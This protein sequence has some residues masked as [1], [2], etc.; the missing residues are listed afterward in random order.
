LNKKRF[1]DI[2][3][4]LFAS[5]RKRLLTFFMSLVVF[6]TTYALILPAITLTSDKQTLSCTYRVHQHTKDCYVEEPVYDAEG[7]LGVIDDDFRDL[8]G[9]A[10]TGNEDEGNPFPDE[11]FEQI[12]VVSAVRCR[13]DDETVH[14]VTSQHLEKFP[15]FFRGFVALREDQLISLREQDRLDAVCDSCEKGRSEK[16][17]DDHTD[18]LAVLGHQAPGLGVGVV[19]QL[20][21]FLEN[22]FPGLTTDLPVVIQGTGNRGNGKTQF[23]GDVF[24]GNLP[25]CHFVSNILKIFV[26]GNVSGFGLLKT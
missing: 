6:A 18:H 21:G 5:R 4:M 7:H 8:D 13:T 2:L 26:F 19:V 12:P 10:Y 24:D 23:P 17:R 11:I 1:K 14:I 15:F 25:M 16:L 20:P 22:E 9:I 3:V